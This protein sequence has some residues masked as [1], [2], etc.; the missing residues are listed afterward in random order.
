MHFRENWFIFLGIWGEAE[1]I[2][3]IWGAKEKKLSGSRGNLG[4]QCIIFRD[5]GSIDP[6]GPQYYIRYALMCSADYTF[7]RPSK[8]GGG[9]CLHVP[10]NKGACSPAPPPSNIR[11]L[12]FPVPHYNLCSKLALLSPFT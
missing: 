10:R 8:S 5:K 9:K 1:L 3:R 4:D 12:M 6:L 2:L 7:A 11:C